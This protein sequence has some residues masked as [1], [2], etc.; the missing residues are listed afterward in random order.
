MVHKGKQELLHSGIAAASSAGA[1]AT[2]T[3]AP[4]QQHAADLLRGGLRQMGIPWPWALHTTLHNDWIQLT[5]QLLQPQ[6]ARPTFAALSFFSNW[7]LTTAD[8][9]FV[10]CRDM[11]CSCGPAVS[12]V[13]HI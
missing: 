13:H 4:P 12:A 2:P 10:A 5:R 9:A 7:R 1:V 8:C 6:T 3:L 11:H